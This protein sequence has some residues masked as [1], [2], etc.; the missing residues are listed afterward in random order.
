MKK[1][2]ITVTILYFANASDNF[3]YQNNK[4]I[5]L[6]PI[7]SIEKLQKKD[8]IQIIDY[9]K[10]ST[11]QTV[12]VTQ[13]I[14]VKIEDNNSVEN[15]LKRYDLNLKQRLTPTIYVVETNSTQQTLKIANSLY[16]EANVS[17]AH[18][19]FIKKIDK[20]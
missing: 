8:S 13:E 9:Y 1:I 18:P 4:K 11:D 12:G 17:Y 19:N 20:R 3:Y 5:E 15:I 16:E 7:Q 10:T 2:I 6:T 14:M